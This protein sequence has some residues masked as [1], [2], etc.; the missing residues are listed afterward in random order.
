MRGARRVECGRY[1]EVGGKL[2]I[3]GRR[4]LA[5]RL[6]EVNGCL[7]DVDGMLHRMTPEQ[8]DAVQAYDKVHGVGLDRLFEI[9]TRGF[10][11]LILAW[12]SDSNT[13]PEELMEDIDPWRD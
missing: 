4:K 8:M 1:R 2:R 5:F 7:N 13:D 12:D 10:T 9:I 6:A 3:L 11:Q